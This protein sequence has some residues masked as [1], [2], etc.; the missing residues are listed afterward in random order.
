MCDLQYSVNSVLNAVK[1]KA[2]KEE[3]MQILSDR[4]IALEDRLEKKRLEEESRAAMASKC[5]SCGKQQKDLRAT[6]AAGAGGGGDELLDMVTAVPTTQQDYEQLVAVLHRNAGLRPMDRQYNS[7]ALLSNTAF[8]SSGLKPP[9]EALVVP[10]PKLHPYAR[11]Q[12]PQYS[13][14]RI[15]TGIPPD[16][17][18]DPLYR[19][20]RYAAHLKELVK[21][22]VSSSVSLNGGEHRYRLDNDNNRRADDGASYSHSLPAA[23]PQMGAGTG[24]GARSTRT[25]GARSAVISSASKLPPS[26]IVERGSGSADPIAGPALPIGSEDDIGSV[27]SDISS[28]TMTEFASAGGGARSTRHGASRR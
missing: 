16:L 6:T 17:S 27:H 19:R 3:V 7:S 8:G 15:S 26:P 22:P 20:A 2:T 25:A 13:T 18:S 11:S 24:S 21:T 4:M 5:L 23:L 10:S 9:G 1:Q 12:G 28:V 14:G